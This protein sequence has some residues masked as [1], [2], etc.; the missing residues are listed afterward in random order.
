MIGTHKRNNHVRNV[1]LLSD[2]K[3]NNQPYNIITNLWSNTSM[4]SSSMSSSWPVAT[5]V[6]ELNS[7]VKQYA[8]HLYH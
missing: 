4:S 8:R 1:V 7:K 5:L 2:G 3:E 6:H